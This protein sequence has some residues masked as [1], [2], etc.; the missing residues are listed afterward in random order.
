MSIEPRACASRS[1]HPLAELADVIVE[2]DVSVDLGVRIARRNATHVDRS[3][4]VSE[5]L[6]LGPPEHATKLPARDAQ[7][8]A[9]DRT[10]P[11]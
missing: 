2:V 1:A 8:S 6:A 4:A 5:G 9:S 11:P 10:P 3:P 7:R